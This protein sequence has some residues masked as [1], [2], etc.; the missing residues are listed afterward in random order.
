MR[1][2]LEYE[3][4]INTLIPMAEKEANAKVALTCVKSVIRPSSTGHYN[5]CLFTEYFHRAM[6]RLA[7]EN[8]LRAF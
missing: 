2:D 8:G 5:H 6:K 4:R 7:I 3:H 1:R